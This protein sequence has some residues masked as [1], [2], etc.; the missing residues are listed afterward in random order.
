M[1]EFISTRCRFENCQSCTDLA[2]A[3]DCHSAENFEFEE[4]AAA[5]PLP[6]APPRTSRQND[7]GTWSPATPLG[8]QGDRLDVEVFGS[9]P[10]GWAAYRGGERVA[11]G[12]ARTRLGLLLSIARIRLARRVMR[13][14]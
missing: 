2:C 1:P 8:F 12:R 5:S 11:S 14:G 4:T 3:H 6:P 10:W 13:R 7:D 9:G